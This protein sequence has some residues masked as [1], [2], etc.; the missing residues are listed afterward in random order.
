MMSR[1]FQS[2]CPICGDSIP[3]A[4]VTQGEAVYVCKTCPAHGDFRVLA[5]EN[6]ADFA[7]WMDFPSVTVPPRMR[8]A[9]GVHSYFPDSFSVIGQGAGSVLNTECPHHC[10]L[11][12]NHLMT[13]CC[14]LL[15]VTE[16]CNQLC[17][18]CFAAA[19]SVTPGIGPQSTPPD[20]PLSVIARWLDRL[21]ELGEERKYNIQLSG[22]EPTVRD[23]LPEIIRLCAEKGFEYI[24]LNTNGRRLAGDG[25]GGL[26]Y[27]QTLK[28]AGLT[29]V[30]LQFDGVTDDVYTALRGEPL[31]ALKQRAIENCGKAGLPVT[32]VPT[33]T[34]G[35]NLGQTGDIVR[36][37][38]ANVSVVKGIHF[39]PASFF[40]RRPD[41]ATEQGDFAERV[42][43]FA[44]M[45][46]IE[47]QTGGLIQKA[48]LA[49]ISTGHPLCCFCAS[50]MKEGDKVKRMSSGGSCCDEEAKDASPLET[51]RR[52]RDFVLNKWTGPIAAE[53]TCCCDTEQSGVMSFDEAIDYFR[54]NMFTISGM[55]FM[56]AT[57]LDAERLRRCRV[58]VFA[59]G[60]R[61][62]P[63][64]GYY[65]GVKA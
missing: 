22:G 53:E 54:N 9:K 37:L 46:E 65:S 57:N 6:A 30:F 28:S 15:N 56:D 61:L 26:A 25:T 1:V 17:P 58:Q 44:V 10:G 12:E 5:S 8:T 32:L 43:M 60:E 29:T 16:R 48:D 7:R 50:F 2:V 18:Y 38:L 11:C 52:D 35:V 45:E 51:I 23:D 64:C 3:A 21:T 27:A 31:L 33:V 14:V 59:D 20:P 40:G 63:F 42:T 62:V 41:E 13:A 4:Y 19:T 24:Q 39:Q 34:K 49:P 55:G 36:F 47:R